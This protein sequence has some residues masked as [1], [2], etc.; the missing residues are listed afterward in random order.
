MQDVRKNT[1][2]K[3]TIWRHS[4]GS[5]FGSVQTEHCHHW[6]C[7]ALG[8]LIT[9]SLPLLSFTVT[10]SFIFIFISPFL[11]N[12]CFFLSFSPLPHTAYKHLVRWKALNLKLKPE[13]IHQVTSAR[14]T[15]KNVQFPGHNHL[16]TTYA[17]DRT[18]DY[19][20]SGDIDF[21]LILLCFVF[22]EPWK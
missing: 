4:F 17:V 3:S 11:T 14:A 12:N 8:L 10:N 7:N 15:S 20:Q 5:K 16:L 18:F 22:P 6:S 1:A 2:Q 19:W 9:V 21:C 13:T